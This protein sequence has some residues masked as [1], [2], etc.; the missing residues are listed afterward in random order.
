MRAARL[1]LGGVAPVPWRVPE[2][3]DVL[4]GSA[5][6]DATIARAAEAATA[7]LHPLSRNGYKLDLI[8]GVVKEA[9]RRVR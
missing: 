2:A 5:L 7:G 8:R 9:L 3:E 6:D 4:V 1:V